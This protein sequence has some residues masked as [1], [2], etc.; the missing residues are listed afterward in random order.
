MMIKTTWVNHI[1]NF[2]AVILGV[3]IAFHISERAK[4]SG[5]KEESIALMKAL[6]DD[7]QS[8]LTTYTDYQIPFNKQYE[9]QVD[10][11]LLALTNNDTDEIHA[12]L[13]QIFQV[14]NYNPTSTTYNSIKSSGKIRLINDLSL[15]RKLSDFYDG[16]AI[17]CENKNQIQVDFFMQELVTWMTVNTDLYE[18]TINKEADMIVLRNKL[19][20]YTSLVAQKIEQ[21]ENIAEDITQLKAQLEA[22]VNQ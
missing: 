20:V 16:A 5:E 4:E 15:Q 18:T 11:L 14:N 3:Y 13:F 8:D 2:V 1:L 7:L 17:E 9:E 19:I 22:T 6:L 10:S 21:Y 12:K